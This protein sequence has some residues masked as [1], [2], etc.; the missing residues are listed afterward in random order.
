MSIAGLSKADMSRSSP[1]VGFVLVL[2]RKRLG[3]D[4]LTVFRQDDIRYVGEI[5][6]GRLSV[7]GLAAR[8][9][10]IS[11]I[12]APHIAGCWRRI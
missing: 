6:I 8:A 4:F 1:V 10:D 3:G 2:F 9:S 11:T 12:L 7:D 5:R